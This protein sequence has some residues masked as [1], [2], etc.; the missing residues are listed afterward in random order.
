MN[1]INWTH[2]FEDY[3]GLW[4]ALNPDDEQTVVGSGKTLRV[5]MEDA[6]RNGYA[7]PLMLDVPEEVVTFVG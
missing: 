7:K 4:V 5:A 6:A 2:I 3:K 1:T